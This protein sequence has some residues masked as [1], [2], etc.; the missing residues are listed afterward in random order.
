MAPVAIDR[1]ERRRERRCGGG[2]RRWQQDG[3]LRPGQPITLINICSRAALVESPA[4]LRPGAHTELQVAGPARRESVKGRLDRCYVSAL[5][6][7]RYRG[8]LMF[9][10]CVDLD[11]DALERRE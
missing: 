9:D 11:V 5:E 8:V 3:V 1:V 2:G 6:P 7:L 10:E 4:R